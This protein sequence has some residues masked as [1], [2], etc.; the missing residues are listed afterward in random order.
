MVSCFKGKFRVTSPRGY[1]NLGGTEAYHGDL[2]LVALEDNTMNI[3]RGLVYNQIAIELAT[4]IIYYRNNTLK[5]GEITYGEWSSYYNTLI[6][7]N[8]TKYKLIVDDNGSLFTQ[9]I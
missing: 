2:D 3:N 4:G 1:R 7:P 6:S 9:A 5:D 8:G